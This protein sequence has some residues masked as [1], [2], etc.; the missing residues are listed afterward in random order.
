MGRVLSTGK[1]LLNADEYYSQFKQSDGTYKGTA[2]EVHNVLIKATSDMIGKIYTISADIIVPVEVT[3]CT[4]QCVVNAAS[5]FSNQ[6]RGGNSGKMIVKFTPAS[7]DD[8]FCITYGSGNYDVT[9]S[10]L[11]LEKGTEATSYEPYTGGVPALYQKNI[12]VGVRG[13]NLFDKTKVVDG[14]FV[15]GVANGATQYNQK[16]SDFIELK[17]TKRIYTNSYNTNN[18]WCLYDEN[19]KFIVQFNDTSNIKDVSSY[20]DAKY[21]RTMCF[22]DN[23]DTYMVSYEQ[24]VNYEP[25]KYQYLPI[26]TPIGLPAIPV[27]SSTSGITYTDADGQAWIADEIDFRRSKYIQRVWQAEFDGSEDEAWSAY[28][29]TISDTF[30]R[31][32]FIAHIPSIQE[33][34]WDGKRGLSNQGKL[35]SPRNDNTVGIDGIWLGR[36]GVKII[37]IPYSSYYDDSI[38]DYGLSNWKAHLAERPLKVMTYLDTPIET[39]LSEEQLQAYK[40]IHTNKPTTIISNDADAWMGASYAADTKLYIDSKVQEIA[41]AV[42]ASASEAE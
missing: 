26:T 34:T 30:I 31:K 36:S 3:Y 42:I 9:F 37:D 17:N 11:Q 16:C 21:I 4:I 19:K 18:Q 24:I 8:Y 14:F 27:P 29:S 38:E 20:P 1:N 23:L 40:A 2:V 22:L 5:H 12:E 39:D 13:K 28:T 33:T 41:S 10:E 7:V 15:N 32:G 35:D 25:H 6:I